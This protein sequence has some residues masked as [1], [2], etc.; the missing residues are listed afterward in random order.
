MYSIH[1]GTYVEEELGLTTDNL[2]QAADRLTRE[3]DSTSDG[4]L[5]NRVDLH[6]AALACRL[7]ARR[8]MLNQMP[9]WD[10]DDTVA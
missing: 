5:P 7:L 10:D 8:I 4:A 2:L 3:A 1:P 6:R 9:K